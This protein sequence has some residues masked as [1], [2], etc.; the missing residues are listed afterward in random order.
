LHEKRAAFVIRRHGNLS[1]EEMGALRP[2]GAV[3]G[4]EFRKKPR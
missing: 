3:E 4:G 2:C 1:C